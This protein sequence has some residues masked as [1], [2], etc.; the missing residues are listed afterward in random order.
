MANVILTKL[1]LLFDRNFHSNDWKD[2]KFSRDDNARKTHSLIQVIK[3]F[4]HF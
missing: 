1:I 3:Y 2:L 4:K